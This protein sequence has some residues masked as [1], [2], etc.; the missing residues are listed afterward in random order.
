MSFSSVDDAISA[1]FEPGVPPPSERLAMLRRFKQRGITCGMYLMPVLPF[2]TDSPLHLEA[3]VR[4]AT[5]A[6]LDFIVFGGLTLREG[7]QREHYMRVLTVHRN[8]LEID[9]DVIFPPS[10]HGA[11][12]QEYYESITMLFGTVARTFHIPPR[13]PLHLFGDYV[14]IN[15]RIAILLEHIEHLLELQGKKWRA[16]PAAWAVSQL[17]QSLSEYPELVSSIP[18]VG[19]KTAQAVREIIERGTCDAYESLTAGF[20]K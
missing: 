3:T 2:I 15:D 1:V 14:G 12:R 18:H 19:P 7:R 20:R 5:E 4:A 9:Y 16:G 8:D 17:K 11:A 10:P 13:I 6:K